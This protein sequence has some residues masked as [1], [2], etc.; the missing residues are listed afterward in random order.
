MSRS[1]TLCS[2]NATVL[3]SKNSEDDASEDGEG[4]T[5]EDETEPAVKETAESGQEVIDA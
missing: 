5:K 3:G 1:N 4:V 2:I